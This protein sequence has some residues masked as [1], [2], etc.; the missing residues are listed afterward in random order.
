MIVARN[1][2]ALL[3]ELDDTVHIDDTQFLQSYAKGPREYPDEFRIKGKL[4]FGGKFH[5]DR[6]VLGVTYYPEDETPFRIALRA[7]MDS[8]LTE[9]V[10]HERIKRERRKQLVF[11]LIYGA[12]A[13]TPSEAIQAFVDEDDPSG[14]PRMHRAMAELLRD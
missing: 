12:F 3:Y 9:L 6:D 4:G 7:T 10:K 14:L 8:R 11:G 13:G 2:L 1:I 5:W